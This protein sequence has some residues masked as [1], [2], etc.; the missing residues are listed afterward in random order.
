MHA[1]RTGKQDFEFS[2]AATSWGR[3][4]AL[5]EVGEAT[6]E[7]SDTRLEYRREGITEWYINGD[8][9]IEHGFDI[10]EKPAGD[11]LLRVEVEVGGELSPRLKSDDTVMLVSSAGEHVLRYTGLVVE[12]AKGTT[13]AAH[14]EVEDDTI[15]I[16]VDDRDAAYPIVIDPWVQ[17]AKLTASD[18]AAG[19]WFGF[20]VAVSGSTIVVGAIYDDARLNSGAAYVFEDSGSGFVQTAS[21]P[22]ATA[23]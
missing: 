1:R 20:S 21:S 3:H 5:N 2:L 8:D 6:I 17:Q 7:A 9:G 13:L 16:V 19:D 11:G 15:A 4:D 18:A 12:D 22:P 14:F 10:A 23:V